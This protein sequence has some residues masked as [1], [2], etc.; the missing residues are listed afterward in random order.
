MLTIE[1]NLGYVFCLLDFANGLSLIEKGS[2][3]TCKMVKSLVGESEIQVKGGNNVISGA[4]REI[5]L[6]LGIMGKEFDFLFGIFDDT[7]F[8][9]DIHLG[10]EALRRS[11]L[12]TDWDSGRIWF[13]DSKDHA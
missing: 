13:S 7:E 12:A 6:W 9:M 3:D 10:I 5:C 2:L 1:V 11:K 4:I 8:P